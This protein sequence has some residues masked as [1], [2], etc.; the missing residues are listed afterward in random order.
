MQ[1][2]TAKC[3]SA[4]NDKRD[5]DDQAICGGNATGKCP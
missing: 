3:C 1:E 2:I 5:L 4:S